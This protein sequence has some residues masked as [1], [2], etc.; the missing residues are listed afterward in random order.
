MLSNFLINSHDV[1]KCS[2]IPSNAS[3]EVEKT[4][5]M[6]IDVIRAEKYSC[7]KFYVSPSAGIL[8][9][10]FFTKIIFNPYD[11]KSIPSL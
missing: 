2:I 3:A 1:R 11:I 8:L 9:I 6:I 10:T 4:G 5:S 7:D